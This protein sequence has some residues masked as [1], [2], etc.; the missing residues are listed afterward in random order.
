M[1]TV[2]DSV[3]TMATKQPGAGKILYQ[4]NIDFCCG[5][6]KSLRSACEARGLDPEKLLAEILAGEPVAQ[7]ID[8]NDK[9][10][11]EL[12]EHIENVFH[13]NHREFLPQVL[14]LA[15]KVE[16]V[17]ADHENC[18]R[19]LT[20]F[21]KELADEMDSHLSREEEGL[22]SAIKAGNKESVRSEVAKLKEDHE[23]YGKGLEK[24]REIVDEYQYPRDA[25]NTWI[26]LYNNLQQL[27]IE[28]K[29]HISLE[30]NVL[31]PKIGVV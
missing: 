24:L 21:L 23:V 7:F 30:N 16:T 31:F 19:G 22:F 18:P 25:C 13:E 27:E 14:F 28:I 15:E 26:V 9:S 8:W 4:N 12:V 17:H 20:V 3:G 29:E 5:G 11:K 10:E 6:K 2:D 1:F